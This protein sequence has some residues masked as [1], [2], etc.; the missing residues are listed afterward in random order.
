MSY[1]ANIFKSEAGY[2]ATM[3]WH[4]DM[5]ARLPDSVEVR[6]VKTRFGET[7]LLAAGPADAP[8]VVLVPGLGGNALLWRTQLVDFA[9]AFR[10]YALDVPGQTGRSAPVHLPHRG[11]AYAEWLVDVFDGLGL[12][13]ADIVGASLGGRLVIKFGAHPAGRTRIRRAVLVSSGGI[14]RMSMRLFG[15]VLPLGFN[16]L[17]VDECAFERLLRV[18]L[19]LPV[20]GPLDDDTAHMMRCFVLFGLHCKQEAA[21]GIPMAL[22][23]PRAELE[24]FAPPTLLIMGAEERIFPPGRAIARAQRLFLHLLAAETIPGAGH[25]LIVQQRADVDAKIRA[26][27][28]EAEQSAG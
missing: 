4:D 12:D 13:R 26:F 10:L 24:A 17:R 11:P 27:L 21:D 5:L 15:R 3:A 23:L 7:H 9:D 2:R 14:V 16:L 28:S 19:T 8:P 25:S 18:V 20:D 6:R 1:P 22:A